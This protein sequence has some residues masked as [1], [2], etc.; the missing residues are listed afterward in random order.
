MAEAARRAYHDRA[1]HL[2]DPD[3]VDVPVTDL[4]SIEYART[5]ASGISLKEAGQS[6]KLQPVAFP[7]AESTE[8]THLS[9][10][11]RWH[12]MVSLTTTLNL[13]FGSGWMAEGTG[14]LLNN[15]MDDF[16]VKP[17][18]ANAFGLIGSHANRVEPGKRPLS[19]MTP[20]L[21]FKDGKP[22]FATGTPGGSRI[23]TMVMQV[24]VNVADFGMNIASASAVPRMHHQWNPD[25]IDL[26][27]GFSPDTIRILQ[28]AGHKVEPS[29]AAGRVQTVGIGDNE[30]LGYC[31]PRSADGAATGVN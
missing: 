5:L 16:S 11:D 7:R 1:R 18:Q 9:V 10:V 12:N 26:E 20:T 30:F 13:N 21:V 27:Q 23:I 17:G 31:D 29:R 25:R 24:I 3:F 14:V 6:N 19:S 22:Y 28:A 4:T 2:G 15:E 8:T